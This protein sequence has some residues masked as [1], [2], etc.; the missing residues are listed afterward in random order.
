M[1]KTDAEKEPDRHVPPASRRAIV[2][3]LASAPVI[4][5]LV[6]GRARAE[7]VIRPG[8]EIEYIVGSC[9]IPP[10]NSETDTCVFEDGTEALK[11]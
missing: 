6:P 5:T 9:A 4:L 3:A 2:K 11:L 7:Y 10:G 8:G 1:A